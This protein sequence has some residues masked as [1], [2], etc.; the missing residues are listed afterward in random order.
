MQ[1][2]TLIA[3]LI[4]PV[5]VVIGI[6]IPLNEANYMA[7]ITEGAASPILIYLGGLVTL[8][9]GVAI[10][11]AYRAWTA[12]WRVIITVLG[13]LLA[14]GGIIRIV[15]PHFTATLATT[16]YSTPTGLRVFAAVM[17]VLGGFLSFEGYRPA[18]K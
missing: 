2:P 12:D 6:G 1:A 5:L 4:G 14:I 8:S 16:L 11:N 18:S 15:L 17:F 7:M 9:L 3:R 10:L 13:W